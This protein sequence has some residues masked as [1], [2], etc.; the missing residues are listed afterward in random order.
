MLFL[1][2]GF[3]SYYLLMTLHV[4]YA[5][6]THFWSVLLN[7]I[8]PLISVAL[9]RGHILKDCD[10]ALILPGSALKKDPSVEIKVVVSSQ[11]TWNTFSWCFLTS[12]WQLTVTVTSVH[13]HLIGYWRPVI[14]M[15][16]P[17]LVTLSES[18]ELDDASSATKKMKN[19]VKRN[20]EEENTCKLYAMICKAI[21]KSS[22]Q[23]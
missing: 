19:E 13:G 6:L 11:A 8:W 14:R 2:T 21:C 9:T 10:S 23:V 5:T 22:R 15:S 3:S 17:S 7:K 12:F 1:S 4:H 16:A 20:E 18:V